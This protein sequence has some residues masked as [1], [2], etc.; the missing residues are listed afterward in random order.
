MWIKNQYKSFVNY[1]LK[2][3]ENPLFIGV[4]GS[5][6]YGFSD[7]DS[8]WDIYS[9][10]VEPTVNIFK[11]DKNSK[12]FLTPE[13]EFYNKLISVKS[14][15]VEVVMH[16]LLKGDCKTFERVL[17]PFMVMKNRETVFIRKIAAMLINRNVVASYLKYSDEELNNYFLNKNVKHLLYALRALLT[18]DILVRSRKLI[19]DYEE[20]LKFYPYS[21]IKQLVTLKLNKSN[22]VDTKLEKKVLE[23]INKLKINIEK[24]SH[25]LKANYTDK[26]KAF[27]ENYLINVRVKNLFSQNA[28]IYIKHDKDKLDEESIG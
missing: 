13:R 24:N 28:S 1:S 20:M 21:N 10:F 27:V 7:K 16:K 23:E 14:E 4:G 17:T 22:K 12:S 26:E 2:Y 19:F 11:L 25:K 5:R 9:V 6:I 3:I 15:E 18:A 8:D